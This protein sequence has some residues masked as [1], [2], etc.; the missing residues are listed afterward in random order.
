MKSILLLLL[1]AL[2]GC[3]T[4]VAEQENNLNAEPVKELSLQNLTEIDFDGINE[5]SAKEDQIRLASVSVVTSGINYL[6]FQKL[7]SD[8]K[9]T[10]PAIAYQQLLK[11]KPQ[12]KDNI[13]CWGTYKGYYI[14]SDDLKGNE[15]HC[16]FLSIYYVKAGGNEF[17]YFYPHT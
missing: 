5:N 6:S 12:L 15:N 13:R 3:S 16:A 4:E 8:Q 17:W 1:I 14:F 10:T 2:V 9:I 11:L 7:I